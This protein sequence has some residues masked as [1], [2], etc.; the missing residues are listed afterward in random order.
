MKS[1]HIILGSLNLHLLLL[2][3][4]VEFKTA[5][6]KCTIKE[7]GHI[8]VSAH[9][10]FCQCPLYSLMLSLIHLFNSKIRKKMDLTTQNSVNKGYWIWRYCASID[11]GVIFL[12]LCFRGGVLKLSRIWGETIPRKPSKSLYI[13]RGLS[14]ASLM[15]TMFSQCSLTKVSVSSPSLKSAPETCQQPPG[16]LQPLEKNAYSLIGW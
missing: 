14:L 4:T 5:S 12:L 2:F 13:L 10:R 16:N 11:A 1:Y 9:V 7:H 3:G 6:L 15:M 8:L